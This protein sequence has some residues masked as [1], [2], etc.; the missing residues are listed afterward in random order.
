VLGPA[1]MPAPIVKRLNEELNVVVTQPEMREFFAREGASPKGGSPD[2]VRRLIQFEVA[3]WSKLI[4][5]GNIE[6]E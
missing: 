3:R 2:D 5:E 6:T 1:R 4:R